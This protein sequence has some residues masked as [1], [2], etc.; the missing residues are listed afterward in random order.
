MKHLYHPVGLKAL[1]K[2]RLSLTQPDIVVIGLPAMFAATRW[3]VNLVYEIAP[4]IVDTA[5]TFMRKLE[6]KLNGR[7]EQAATLIDKTFRVRG[8]LELTEYERLIRESIE[9]CRQTSRCRVILF[10]PGRF[11]ED[12]TQD[13]P[14]H[15]PELWSSV[16]QMI[17]RLGKEFNVPVISVQDALSDYGGEVF[18]PSDHRFSEYGHEVVAREVASVIA[19]QVSSL[20]LSMDEIKH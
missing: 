2:H 11:N 18:I 20:A 8:P 10:G 7:G 15:S 17:E 9:Y 13:Y 5:R 14:I 16:N 3:R 4:E 19:A 1:L 12:T 6:T